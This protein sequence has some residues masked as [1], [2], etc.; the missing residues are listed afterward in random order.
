MGKCI[1][2]FAAYILLTFLWILWP[3]AEERHCGLKMKHK[4][5]FLCCLSMIASMIAILFGILSMNA[6]SK[7]S[8]G[9]QAWI[10]AE[11]P[12]FNQEYAWSDDDDGQMEKEHS[13]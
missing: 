5:L 11:I 6:T 4:C 8:Q 10:D 2:C 13:S 3:D 12:S 7:C 9:L 1:A